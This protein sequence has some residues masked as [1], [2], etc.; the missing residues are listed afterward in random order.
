MTKLDL[1]K[2]GFSQGSIFTEIPQE[3]L[4]PIE[5]DII[6]EYWK[7]KSHTDNPTLRSV[8]SILIEDVEQ[9]DA[10]KTIAQEISKARKLDH[11]EVDIALMR[12]RTQ[13]QRKLFEQIHTSMDN[14][15]IDLSA[16]IE[17][18]SQLNNKKTEQ[19]QI[20]VNAKHWDKLQKAEEEE[21]WLFLDWLTQNNVPIKKKVLYS[22][23]ATT[24]G[25]KTILKTWFAHHLIRTGANV[26]YLAQEE[27]YSDTIRRIHQCTLGLTEPQYAERTRESFEQIGEQF[28]KIAEEKGYGNFY[29]AEWPGVRVSSIEEYIKQHTAKTDEKIDALIVDY[30]KLVEVDSS[31]KNAQEWERIG[32]IFKELKQLAMKLNIAVITSIQ[33]NREASKALIERS[34]TPDLHDVAGAFEATHH[35]NYVWSVMLRQQSVDNIDFNDVNSILGTYTLTVQKQKYGNLRKGDS[36]TFRWTTDHN[37]TEINIDDIEIPELGPNVAF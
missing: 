5:L 29:V 26:L 13:A 12:L 3:I 37:L 6:K 25:G 11:A 28:N 18:L 21:I 2:T 35:A 32:L 23:I 19:L 27:P 33:L 24:N 9:R 20:P 15:D 30:G 4:D 7:Q 31:K 34:Q 1:L 8:L 10:Y 16:Y 17:R 14:P 36:K 22:F